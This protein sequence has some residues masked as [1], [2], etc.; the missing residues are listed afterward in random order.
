MDPQRVFHA[1]T[2]AFPGVVVDISSAG[3]YI[4]KVTTKIHRVE[5]LC[6]GVKA[7]LP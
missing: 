6:R 4:S 5:E 3:E 2:S 7:V 1:L